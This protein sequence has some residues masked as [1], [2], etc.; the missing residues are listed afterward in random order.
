MKSQARKMQDMGKP[1]KVGDDFYGED[2]R[3]DTVEDDED[4]AYKDND[5]DY[6]D[7][8]KLQVD[9][10]IQNDDMGYMDNKFV[11]KKELWITLIESPGE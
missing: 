11:R 7:E 1:G 8:D 5:D 10:D 6:E 9:L 2:G 3:L 4:F